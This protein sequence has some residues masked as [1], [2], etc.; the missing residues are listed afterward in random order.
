[1]HWNEINRWKRLR[2]W[3]IL[4]NLNE[5]FSF[6]NFNSQVGDLFLSK[7]WFDILYFFF[8]PMHIGYD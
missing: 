6:Y 5:L 4:K 3:A 2:D 7:V 1:M 8:L